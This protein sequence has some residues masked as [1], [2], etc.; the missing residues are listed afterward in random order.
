MKIE[1]LKE[2]VVLARCL[3]YSAAAQQLFITQ[4]VLSRHIASIEEEFG[5][6]LLE[7]D[8]HNVALTDGGRSSL[9]EIQALVSRYD[10]LLAHMERTSKGMA[11]R[12]RIGFLNYTMNQ[13][14]SPVI[15]QLSK[16]YPQMIIEPYPSRSSE[17]IDNLM[18]DRIDIG[19][20][21]RVLLPHD[22][23]FR[24]HNIYKEPLTTFVSRNNP[25]AERDSVSN[26]DLEN[27][28]FIEIDDVYQRC[29]E[30][31]IR[32]LCIKH[33]FLPQSGPTVGSLEA[34][35]LAVQA[36]KGIYILPRSAKTWNLQSVENIDI[37]DEDCFMYGCAG[38]RKTNGNPT[39][40]LVI[41]EYEKIINAK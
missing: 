1:Y 2:F 11:G 12:V 7:R 31:E 41:R 3:N 30:N 6:K 18:S 8:T 38:Y 39:V 35:I 9:K 13:Y 23:D 28:L 33:D 19:L 27:E 5:V 34:A 37:V 22:A 26:A 17:I 20:F 24:Y 36:G 10:S 32:R 15:E 40:P 4:P 14:V 25:L 29:Y 16:S 21:M